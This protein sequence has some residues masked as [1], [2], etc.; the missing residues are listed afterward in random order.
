MTV[1]VIVAQWGF[2]KGEIIE[3]R[4]GGK[5]MSGRRLFIPDAD[6]NLQLIVGVDVKEVDEHEDSAK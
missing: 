3:G 1:K 5:L 4:A 6:P 2:H